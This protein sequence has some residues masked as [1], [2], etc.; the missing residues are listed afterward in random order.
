MFELGRAK[1]LHDEWKR[2]F[3]AFKWVKKLGTRQWILLVKRQRV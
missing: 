2:G 3:V 1:K